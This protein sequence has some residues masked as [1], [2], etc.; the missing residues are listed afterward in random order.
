MV[1][2]LCEETPVERHAPVVDSCDLVEAATEYRR[3]ATVA[4]YR[5]RREGRHKR[6]KPRWFCLRCARLALEMPEKVVAFVNAA[7]GVEA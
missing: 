5:G 7:Y 1:H 3:K 2:P 6:C 4:K